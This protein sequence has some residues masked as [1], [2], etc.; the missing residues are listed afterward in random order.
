LARYSNPQ[1]FFQQLGE[2]AGILVRPSSQSQLEF[3]DVIR[4]EPAKY[5][6]DTPFRGVAEL[7]SGHYGF[8]LDA[9]PAER[10]E[11]KENEKA[12][13]EEAEKKEESE[14]SLLSMLG[15]L[16]VPPVPSQPKGKVINYTRLYFDL[17]HNGDLTDDEPIEA[18]SSRA[19]STSMVYSIFPTVELTMDVHGTTVDY[20]FTVRVQSRVTSDYGYASAS[21]NSAAYREGEVTLDGKK[22]RIVLIDFNSNGRFDD[23]VSFHTSGGTVSPVMGDMLFIDPNSPRVSRSLYSMASGGSQYP[24]GKLI[25][26]AG[27]FFD[28]A[29]DPSGETLSLEPTSAPIGYVTNPNKDF[30]AVVYG[31]QGIL[32][33]SRDDAGKIPIPQGEWRLLSYTIDRAETLEP[34]AEKQDEEKS[35]LE[36]LGSALTTPLT[37]DT[38]PRPTRVSA[39]TTGDVKPVKVVKDATAEMRFGPPYTPKV[40]AGTI[41][42]GQSAIPLSLSLVGVGGEVCS[43]ISVNG[44]RP[45]AP[46]FTVSTKDGEEVAVGKFKYG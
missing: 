39:R 43:G 29:I 23:A 34:D 2:P 11:K 42:E 8:V 33:I 22:R 27:R 41:R 12:D 44:K 25:G 35:V 15:G 28:L 14:G 16:I 20:A 32:E 31:D 26:I 4:K 18:S 36:L 6:A 45:A 46:E 1:N 19:Y 10:E 3:S 30:S 13:E 9:A 7:G 17:N 24:V 21:L 37:P 40:T 38:P 5:I